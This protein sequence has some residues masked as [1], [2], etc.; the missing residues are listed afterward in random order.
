M[1]PTRAQRLQVVQATPLLLA[2]VAHCAERGVAGGFQTD[3]HSSSMT[4]TSLANESRDTVRS[5]STMRRRHQ[6]RLLVRA[7]CGC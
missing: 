2:V 3:P 1:C 5:P 4:A 6:V 7:G